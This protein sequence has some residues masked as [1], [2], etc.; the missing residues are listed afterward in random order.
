MIGFATISSR[1]IS[2]AD[3]SNYSYLIG[4]GFLCDL[5]PSACPTI[6]KASNG[7]TIEVTGSGTLSIHPKSVTGEGTFVHKDAEGDVV[8]EGTW[9]AEQLLSLHSY[10][11]ASAQGLP[12]ELEGGLALIRVGLYVEGDKVG[13]AT[14]QIDCVL[15][16]KIPNSATEGIRLAV[17]SGPNFNK[18]VS[19]FTVFIRE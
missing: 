7:D 14:L 13:T 1:S 18:E 6:S 10:G 3:T 12:E 4:T 19:G 17:Q 9:T 16:D 8:A 15:G 2:A 11:S 5:D